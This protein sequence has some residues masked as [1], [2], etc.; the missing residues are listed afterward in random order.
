MDGWRTTLPRD[1]REIYERAVYEAELEGGKVVFRIG[2]EAQGAV[3]AE[4]LVILT[5]WNPGYERP[6]LGFNRQANERL[7]SELQ[8]RGHQYYPA[9]GRTDDNSHDEPSIA[10]L[11]MFPEEAAELARMFRQAAF[12]YWD[13][14]MARVMASEDLLT[15]VKAE[16]AGA[17]QIVVRLFN[18]ILNG[19]HFS[20]LEEVLAHDYYDHT[21]APGQGRG[22]AG[23]RAKIQALR[24]AFPDLRFELE[25]LIS[26]RDLVAARW[27][28]TGAHQGSLGDIGP[29][30]QRV[31]MRGMDFYRIEGGR[32]AEHW[33]VTDQLGLLTQLGAVRTE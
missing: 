20:G 2:Q 28:A 30:G 12:F 9:L 14:A 5:G 27:H 31:M 3:P 10:V 29:T 22:A 8:R 33:D 23:V 32:I 15:G 6:G 24:T 19:S 26:E 7:A 16:E 17:K 21:P 18:E 25:T 11:G 1:L 13:G 4:K